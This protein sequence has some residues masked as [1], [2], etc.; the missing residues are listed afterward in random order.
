MVLRSKQLKGRNKKETIEKF[1]QMGLNNPE[2][3]TLLESLSFRKS[4]EGKKEKWDDSR[5]KLKNLKKSEIS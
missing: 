1:R 5:I 2:R 3:K 4:L